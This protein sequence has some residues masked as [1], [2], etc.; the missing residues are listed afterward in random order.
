[1][2]DKHKFFFEFA[3][4]YTAQLIEKFE[5]SPAHPLGQVSS[6]YIEAA[7]IIVVS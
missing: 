4:A 5:A 2:C 6:N 3:K 7:R 1:M